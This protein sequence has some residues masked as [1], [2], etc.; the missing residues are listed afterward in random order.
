VRGEDDSR[1][2]PAE[3]KLVDGRGARNRPLWKTNSISKT[4]GCYAKM[5]GEDFVILFLSLYPIL[6]LLVVID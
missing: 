5:R 2:R 4:S 3:N 1:P 6:L